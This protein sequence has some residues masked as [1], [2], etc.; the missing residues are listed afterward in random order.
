M[1][2]VKLP[3][4]LFDIITPIITYT[5]AYFAMASLGSEMDDASS[6]YSGQPDGR[7]QRLIDDMTWNVSID[8]NTLRDICQN[9]VETPVE[10]G[11][12]TTAIYIGAQFLVTN[13][14]LHNSGLGDASGKIQNDWKPFY[15]SDMDKISNRDFKQ[16]RQLFATL[17]VYLAQTLEYLE[18]R[19]IP[20]SNDKIL[21]NREAQNKSGIVKESAKVNV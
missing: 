8:M 2:K 7:C 12:M 3:E 14:H 15:S 10:K 6:T 1:I 20:D 16:L 19:N 9:T 21:G 13:P 18:G 17:C 4:K 11:D 5:L